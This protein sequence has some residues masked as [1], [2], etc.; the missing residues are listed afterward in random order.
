MSNPTLLDFQNDIKGYNSYAAPFSQNKFSA[1]LAAAGNAT[2]TVPATTNYSR[3][4][5][6]FSYGAGSNIWVS[7]DGTAAAPAGG[8]FASTTSQLLPGA[9][10]V[11]TGDTINVLNS[12]AGAADVGAVFYAIS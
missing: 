7:V 3:W 8:T 6:A 2:I 1:T 9:L 5:V 11:N 12:G 4:V 10:A